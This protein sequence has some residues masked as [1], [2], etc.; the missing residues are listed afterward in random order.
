MAVRSVAPKKKVKKKDED[1]TD[2]SGIADLIAPVSDLEQPM[3]ALFYGK[4]GSGKTAL[5]ATFPKPILFLDIR[6]RGLE[7]IAKEEDIKVIQVDDWVRFERMYWYLKNEDHGFKSVILDQITALQGICM[8]QVR[9]DDNLDATDKMHRGQWGTISGLMQQWLL[10]YRDLRDEG[11]CVA[12]LAHDRSKS[13][14]DDSG[15]DQIDPSVG[16]RLMPSVTSF[17]N[18]MVSVIGNTF[19]REKN[20]KLDGGKKEKKAEYRL[21]IGPHAYYDTKIRRPKDAGPIPESILNPS[22]KKLLAISRGE[23]ISVK[24][25]KRSK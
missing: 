13:S 12:F 14:E 3:T 20:V 1:R 23:D 11:M 22:Y 17:V 19:I 4:S 5:A 2:Y 15:E 24:P 18:G 10:N 7:T 6:E 21:R 8:D 25:K 9:K 16:A